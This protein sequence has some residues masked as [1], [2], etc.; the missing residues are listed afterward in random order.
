MMFSKSAKFY[1]AIY[2]S[3]DKDYVAEAEKVH[4]FIRKYKK[5]SGD[6]LLEVACGTGLHAGLLQ[7]YYRVEGLD[8]DA[9]MVTVARQNHPDIL[10]HQA[11]M[12]DFDLGRQFDIVTCLFSSIGY[13][14]TRLRLKRA[15]QAMTRHLVPGGVIL[16]E[17]WFTPEQWH[18][19]RIGGT[20]VDQ[21]DLKIARL[22][23]S[24]IKNGISTI[25][26]QYLVGTSQGIEHFKEQHELGL[27][28]HE[29]Y[30]QAFRAAQLDV[31]HD[32]EG[33]D[34]RGLYIGQKR[35]K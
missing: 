22:S 9:E 6:T 3:L 21:P 26:F 5:S 15:V 1:D 31:N 16:I 35:Q 28:A 33:L 17:P 11:N 27:F 19:G 2:A 32:L 10:F 12:V 29:D 8:L 13:V 23:L 30:L 4:Q 18:S 34:G 7:K 20:L 24:G 14:K 25:T